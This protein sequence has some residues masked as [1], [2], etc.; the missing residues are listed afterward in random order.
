MVMSFED[1]DDET[2][3]SYGIF[4]TNCG[5]GIESGSQFCTNCGT[6]VNNQQINNTQTVEVNQIAVGII[7]GSME[8]TLKSVMRKTGVDKE[9]F[10]TAINYVIDHL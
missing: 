9:A 5:A 8:N 3:V 2:S 7:T 6:P 4:C 1:D 10:K